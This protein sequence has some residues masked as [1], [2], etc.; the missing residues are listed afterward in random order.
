MNSMGEPLGWRRTVR[1]KATVDLVRLFLREEAAGEA[2][3]G[4]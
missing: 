3:D 1:E 4:V 2:Q